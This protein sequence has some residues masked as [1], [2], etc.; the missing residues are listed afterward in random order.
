MARKVDPEKHEEKRLE[1][2][3]AAHC[4][5]L[6]EG[7]RGASTAMICKEA[8]ISPGHLYHYFASKEVIVEAMA[9][10]Y[11][12]RLHGYFADQP[13][14]AN[15]STVLLSEI[16]SMQG[17]GDV[18][19]CR[20]LFEL[21]AEAGRNPRIRA[22]LRENTSGVHAVLSQTLRAGQ[23]KGEVDAGL[24]PDQV[25]AMLI[26]VVDAAPMLPLMVE[27]LD[28]AASRD[29]LTLMVRRFLAPQRE[30]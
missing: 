27:G 13:E 22:I 5:F 24:D 30:V 17:W 2:L 6:R 14:G 29:L 16:W 11:L 12:R 3:E 4:C 19:H 26:A 28:F 8:G 23:A 10:D 15:T 21:L 20:I 18:D 25:A 1:L 7:L 9:E